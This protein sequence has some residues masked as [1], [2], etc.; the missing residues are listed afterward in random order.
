MAGFIPELTTRITVKVNSD[1]VD[2]GINRIESDPYLSQCPSIVEALNNV[3]TKLQDLEEPVA[4]SV[5]ER[6]QSNQEIIISTK[7]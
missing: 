4:S 2:E 5:A 6:L 1:S 3:K 7:H